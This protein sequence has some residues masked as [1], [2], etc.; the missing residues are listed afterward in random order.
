[1]LALYTGTYIHAWLLS[2]FSCV[3]LF[4][5]LWTI[6]PQAPLSLGFSRQEY[7]TRLSC[8]S[9]EHLPYPGIE[10]VSL[11]SPATG[12]CFFLFVFTTITTW[13]TLNYKQYKNRSSRDTT[14]HFHIEEFNLLL[15]WLGKLLET[16][17]YSVFKNFFLQLQI[18]GGSI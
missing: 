12:R 15:I 3:W 10:P 4:V 16:Q 8:P 7:W 13:E 17:D 2:H 11:M 6:A 5:T 9:P 14:L 18:Y 1:M